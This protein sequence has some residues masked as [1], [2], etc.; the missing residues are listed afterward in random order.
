VVVG[1]HGRALSGD[2]A[3]VAAGG[4]QVVDGRERRVVDVERVPL[5]VAVAV[6]PPPGPGARDELHGP[7][8]AVIDRV[9]VQDAVV[10]ITDERRA[11]A[12]QRDTDDPGRR[13]SVRV[14]D[15]TGKAPVVGLDA[16]DP[17]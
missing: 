8:R 6:G 14:Q 17:G 1:E 5:A 11:G 10:G 3:Q 16:P 15:G 9:A 7:D 4:A 12:V 2:G 13:G